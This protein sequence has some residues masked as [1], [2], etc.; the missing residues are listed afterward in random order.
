MARRNVAEVPTVPRNT[1]RGMLQVSAPAATA[2]DLVGYPG[3]AGGLSNVTTVLS[4]LAEQP[5]AGALL[6][7]AERSP[8]TNSWAPSSAHCTSAR[9][10]AISSTSTW[11]DV[12]PTRAQ[13]CTTGP[14]PSVLVALPPH[15]LSP[16][17]SARLY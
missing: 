3:H 13:G 5:N 7:E 17:H 15:S 1:L 9:R 10:A 2:Y 4:D 14:L 6:A 16:T 12:A 11:P 8:S